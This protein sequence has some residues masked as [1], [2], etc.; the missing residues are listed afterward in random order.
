MYGPPS[1]EIM[2]R[3]RKM[4]AICK[5]NG[6]P[7]AAAALQ[8]PLAHPTMAAVIPGA[9]TADE[10]AENS[11]HLNTPIPEDVWKSFKEDGLLD[12]DVPTPSAG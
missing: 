11:R 5:R 9:K 7:L 10:A 12:P 2:D 8:F 4:D 1:E 3:A 6:V